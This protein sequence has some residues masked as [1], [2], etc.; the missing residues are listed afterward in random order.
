MYLSWWLEVRFISNVETW[1]FKVGNA[2][3]LATI[4]SHMFLLD[5]GRTERADSIKAGIPVYLFK[6]GYKPRMNRNLCVSSYPWMIMFVLQFMY[7]VLTGSFKP[8]LLLCHI[9]LML[10]YKLRFKLYIHSCSHWYWVIF[11]CKKSII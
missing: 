5:W 6:L 2:Y 8:N 10:I 7:L 9:G 11:A 1:R 3:F 4:H